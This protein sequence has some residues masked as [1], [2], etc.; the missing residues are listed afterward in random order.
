MLAG[1]TDHSP[2]SADSH[3]PRPAAPSQLTPTRIEPLGKTELLLAWT[4][5]EE[6]AVPYIEIRYYCPCAGC[7]DENSGERTVDR[8]ALDPEVRPV[9]VQLVGRYAVQID[10]SDRHNTGMYHFER[11]YELSVKQGRK[12][13]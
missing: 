10:W 13:K 1:M 5:G 7:V 2:T 12:L 8:S 3:G 9:G 4:N 11:L 6:Y